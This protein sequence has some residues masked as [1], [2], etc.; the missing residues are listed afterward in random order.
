MDT[1]KYEIANL[2]SRLNEL[3]TNNSNSQN[4]ILDIEKNGNDYKHK[5]NEFYNEIYTLFEKLDEKIVEKYHNTTQLK[6]AI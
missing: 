6:K 2:I 4:I 3:D 5:F 1:L